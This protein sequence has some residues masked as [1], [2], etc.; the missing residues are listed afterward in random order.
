[1][2]A[3]RRYLDARTLTPSARRHP[4]ARAD[5]E[6]PS[7][8]RPP[9]PP[10]S[11]V[12]ADEPERGSASLLPVRGRPAPARPSLNSPGKLEGASRT[13]R[14]VG[15]RRPR[16]PRR[17]H[18]GHPPVHGAP[19]LGRHRNLGPAIFRRPL[20]GCDGIGAAPRLN[21]VRVARCAQRV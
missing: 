10:R 1:V 12:P 18:P 4:A 15:R 9:R 17:R 14:Q 21:T 20:P 8:R 6:P 16:E 2:T 5:C 3:Q 19:D 11:R 7:P 13:G